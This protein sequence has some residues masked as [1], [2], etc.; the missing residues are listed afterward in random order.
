[1][2]IIRD[3]EETRQ[4]TPEVVPVACGPLAE[5]PEEAPVPV[6]AATPS[7]ESGMPLLTVAVVA[8]LLEDGV[9][10]G[11]EGVTVSPTV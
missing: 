1:M 4:Y 9:I 2:I 6:V 3:T 7:S 5:A 10:Y 8:Q 11:A